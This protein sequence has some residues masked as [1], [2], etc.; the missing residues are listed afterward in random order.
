MGH[1]QSPEQKKPPSRLPPGHQVQEGADKL[2]SLAE[3]V[4]RPGSLDHGTLSTGDVLRLQ[5]TLGNRRVTSLLA[6]QLT[7]SAARPGMIQLGKINP[8]SKYARKNR[9][10]Y[11]IYAIRHKATKKVAY[12]GQTVASVGYKNRFKQH[13]RE[14]AWLSRK[15]YTITLLDSGSWTPFEANAFE[16]W[17][18]DEYGGLGTLENKVLALTRAKYKLYRGLHGKGYQGSY[19]WRPKN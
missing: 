8:N 17:Y 15:H 2:P 18:I 11:Q 13:L 6:S 12:V 19:N 16:Q 1:R 5:R 10:K 14:K 3:E 4:S 7:F 9:R